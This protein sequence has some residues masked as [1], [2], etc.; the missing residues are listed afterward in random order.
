MKKKN[1]CYP[2]KDYELIFLRVKSYIKYVAN[3]AQLSQN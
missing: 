2:L 3:V 1:N